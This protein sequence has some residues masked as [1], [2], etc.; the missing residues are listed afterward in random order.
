MMLIKLYFLILENALKHMN[1]INI[2]NQ[3]YSTQ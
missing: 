1:D 3:K 2:A